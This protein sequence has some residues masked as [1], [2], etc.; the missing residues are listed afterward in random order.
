[1]TG[2]Y[3]NI[4]SLQNEKNL[5]FLYRAPKYELEPL[6]VIAMSNSYMETLKLEREESDRMAKLTKGYSYAFQVLGYLKYSNGKKLD[7]L[8]DDFDEI[9]FE[10]SYEKI[11]SELSARERDVVKTLVKSE[12]GRMKVKDIIDNTGLTTQ[13]FPTYRKR[14][15]GSGVISISEYGYCELALPR[16]KEI[17]GRWLD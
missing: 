3:N 15:G 5:T 14:L 16:F 2:L 10:Y 7:E 17:V 4:R 11:W 8:L 1:M 6:N 12:S 13:S 9:M